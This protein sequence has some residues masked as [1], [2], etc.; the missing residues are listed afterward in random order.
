MRRQRTTPSTAGLGPASIIRL[1]ASRC[2][3]LS[4][5]RLPGALPSTSPEGPC[6]LKATTHLRTPELVEGLP[7]DTADRRRLVAR[8]A[9]ID[10]RQRQQA[11][12]LLGIP[13]GFGQRTQVLCV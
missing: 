6:A 8:G 13:R 1:S 2:A 5:G 4:S 3:G 10:R 9:F 12:G 7:R 11:P